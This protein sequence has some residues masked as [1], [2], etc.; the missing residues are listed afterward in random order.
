MRSDSKLALKKRSQQAVFDEEAPLSPHLGRSA[1]LGRAA[2]HVA[3]APLSAVI[4]VWATSLKPW[5]EPP[6]GPQQVGL[7][8]H[9]HLACKLDIQ[10]VAQ[11]QSQCVAQGNLQL[12][13]ADEVVEHRRVGH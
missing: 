12:A 5:I 9:Q 3:G 7:G 1:C 11:R 10:V 13:V 8:V 6:P 2:H 4:P